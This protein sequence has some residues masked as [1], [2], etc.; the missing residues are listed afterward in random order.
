MWTSGCDFDGCV[1]IACPIFIHL[2][3][4]QIRVPLFYH[5]PSCFFS[6]LARKLKTEKENIRTHKNWGAKKRVTL[7][8]R[9]RKEWES[10]SI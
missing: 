3:R 10:E 7:R 2:A 5:P 6:A 9:H 1:Q 8:V 4:E